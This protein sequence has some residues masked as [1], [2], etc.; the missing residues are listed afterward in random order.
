[1]IILCGDFNLPLVITLVSKFECSGRYSC[2]HAGHSPLSMASYHDHYTVQ[3]LL[4]ESGPPQSF[5]EPNPATEGSFI[6]TKAVTHYVKYNWYCV[7]N[8]IKTSDD[9]YPYRSEDAKIIEL[10]KL[11]NNFHDTI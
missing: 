11:I 3:P 6:Y 9:I 4:R 2:L 10:L 5:T 7:V 8:K 1:M